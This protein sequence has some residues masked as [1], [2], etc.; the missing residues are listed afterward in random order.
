LSIKIAQWTIHHMQDKDGYFYF[1]IYPTH[2]NKMPYIRWG[3]APMIN[4]LTL[5]L[6]KLHS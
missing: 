4:A 5:L 2:T 1:R 6:S 3:Q